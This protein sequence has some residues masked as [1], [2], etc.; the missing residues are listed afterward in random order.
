MQ[1]TSSNSPFSF[2]LPQ[3]Q[4]LTFRTAEP[5]S[6]ESSNAIPDTHVEEVKA[7]VTFSP[8]I[9]E[10]IDAAEEAFC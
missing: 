4:S 9:V 2:H 5:V 3:Q 1:A 10:L 8:D 6:M 7:L